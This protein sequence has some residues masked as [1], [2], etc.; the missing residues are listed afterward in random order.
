MKL[1]S[2]IFQINGCPVKICHHE[3]LKKYASND[4]MFRVK[5]YGF[6]GAF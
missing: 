5:I 6:E 3:Y 1:F 2:V 4:E